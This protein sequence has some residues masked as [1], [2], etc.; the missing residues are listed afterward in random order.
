MRERGL[1]LDHGL[2]LLIGAD[3]PEGMG[4]QF[5]RLPERMRDAEFLARFGGI[6]DAVTRVDPSP[7]YPVRAATLHPGRVPRRRHWR[8]SD[9]SLRRMPWGTGLAGPMTARRLPG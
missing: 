3:V 4:A 1:V 5:A 2:V 6:H 8:T 9:L 7:S